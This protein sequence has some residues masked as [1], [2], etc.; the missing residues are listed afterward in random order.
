[1]SKIDTLEPGFKD[2]VEIVLKEAEEATGHKWGVVQARRSIAEQDAL[3][4]QGRTKPGQNVTKAKGGQ[5]A[6]N[7]GLAVDLV[8]IKDKKEWWSAPRS[9][10]LK[11]AEI[12][13]KH[14]LVAGI[15]WTDL[16]P[17]NGDMPH[18][19]DP[20]WKEKQALWKAGKL[21]VA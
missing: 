4:A 17:P 2:T 9:L 14:G 3:Y 12:A 6:H 16:F 15:H 11:M 8:P 5:S 18:I 21:Q 19:Q 10:F 20:K 13:E 1:M 7:F